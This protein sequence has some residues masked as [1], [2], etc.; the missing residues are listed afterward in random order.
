MFNPF[1]SADYNF[2]FPSA[3]RPDDPG[4]G[5]LILLCIAALTTAAGVLFGLF[6]AGTVLVVSVLALFSWRR[7]RARA[8]PRRQ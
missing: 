3:R 5:W 2:I 1:G 6:G 7:R 4:W 8:A